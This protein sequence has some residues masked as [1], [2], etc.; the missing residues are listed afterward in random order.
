MNSRTIQFEIQ[1]G[2]ATGF[3]G[4][5]PREQRLSNVP[6]GLRKFTLIVSIEN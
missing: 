6:L 3:M 2:P 5:T 4:V 1:K